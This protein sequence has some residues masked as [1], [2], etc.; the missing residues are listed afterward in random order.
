M[1][2]YIVTIILILCTIFLVIPNLSTN[3]SDYKKE[4]DIL[5]KTSTKAGTTRKPIFRKRIHRVLILEMESHK[6]WYISNEKYLKYWTEIQS[7]NNIGKRFTFYSQ[8]HI[9]E[10][11]NP[12]R[13]EIENKV[14]YDSSKDKI[15]E[16][17]ILIITICATY[18]SVKKYK[19][20]CSQ[21]KVTS[22]VGNSSLHDV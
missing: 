6:K 1:K 5:L 20:A 2:L 13:L 22:S 7:P 18:F 8:Y 11:H 17:L 12:I 14:I 9:T 4:T 3:L 15:L 16:Y 19:K 10:R 21:I